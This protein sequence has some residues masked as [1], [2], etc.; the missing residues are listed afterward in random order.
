MT[1]AEQTPARDDELTSHGY[2]ITLD[3]GRDSFFALS[4]EDEQSDD[5]WL[6]SDTVRALDEMR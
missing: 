4:I 6:M 3:D 2:H 1:D 5:A